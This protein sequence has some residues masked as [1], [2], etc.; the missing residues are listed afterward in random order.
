MDTYYNYYYYSQHFVF[1]LCSVLLLQHGS[2]PI[3]GQLKV[4]V[5][6]SILLVTNCIILF[7]RSVINTT[8]A[9]VKILQST[10]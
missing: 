10:L 9:I 6:Y 5:F 3:A 2:F 4:F 1:L 7:G 8:I